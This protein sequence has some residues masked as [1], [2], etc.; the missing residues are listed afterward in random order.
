MIRR[1]DA[2]T[3][4]F[5]DGSDDVKMTVVSESVPACWEK[6]GQLRGL[7]MLRV[8]VMELTVSVT[9]AAATTNTPEGEGLDS[10]PSTV[11]VTDPDSERG[12]SFVVI[13]NSVDADS[14][15]VWSPVMRE[16]EISDSDDLYLF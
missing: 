11:L 12:W 14:G 9:D 5:C 2:P 3:L 8:N 1:T 13:V 4:T 10:I 15:V 6:R 7:A 16:R